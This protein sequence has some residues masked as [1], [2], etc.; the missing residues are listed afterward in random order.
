MGLAACLAAGHA[1]LAVQVVFSEVMYRPTAGKPEF[2]ELWNITHTPL[3]IAQWRFTRG[4]SYTFPEFSDA[5]PQAHILQAQE[6]IV[7]SAAS[8]AETRAAYP[9]IPPDVRVFGPWTGALANEGEEVILEDKNGVVICLLDY[10]NGGNWPKAADGTGHSLV[11]RNEN[12][13]IDSFRNW[14]ASRYA[15]GTPGYSEFGAVTPFP[16][17]SPEVGVGSA[18]VM[19]DYGTTW[20]WHIPTSNPGTAWQGLGFDDSGWS[21]G[22]GLLGFENAG[23]PAPGMQTTVGAPNQ[24]MVTL[25]RKTFTFAGSPVGATVSIDQVIDDGV[26]YYLNGQLLGASGHSP[27]AW[28]ASASRTVGDASEELDAIT[29]PASGLVNGENVLAASVHQVNLSSS[30]MVFGARLKIGTQPGLVINEVKPG[31][32]GDGFVEIYNTTGSPI[33]LQNHYLSDLPGN[34][35]K[36]RIEADLVVPANGYAVIGFAESGLTVGATT[37]VYLTAPDGATA[38][39]AISA[40][41]PVDGRSLGRQ[42]AGGTGW[43]LFALPTPGA[44]NGS[45]TAASFAL[46]LSEAHFSEGGYVDW[47]ELENTDATAGSADGL[48]LA[49]RLDFADRIPLSGQIPGGGFASWDCAFPADSDGTLTLWLIDAGRNVLGWAE[50]RRVPG[51]DSLQALWPPAVPVKPSWEDVPERPWWNATPDHTR[52]AAN[53]PGLQTAIVINEIMPDPPSDH[54]NGEFVELHNRSA[55]PV[56]LTGWKLRGGAD[57]DFAPGATVPAGGFLLVGGDPAFLMATYPGTTAVGPWSGRLANRGELLR[58][59]DE[60]GNLAD[61]V[62]YGVGG[63]W[64]TLAAAQGS[65]LELL[66][67]DMDNSR[68]SAWRASDEASKSEWQTFTITGPWTQLRTMGGPSDYKELHLFLVGDSHIA[69]RNMHLSASTEPGTNLLPGGGATVSANGTGV[70]GWLC[71]GTHAQSYAEDGEFHLVSDGRG[72]N[73]PNRAEIDVTGLT[74]GRTYTLTFEARWISGKNR[75][76]VQTWDHSFGAP[77]L[78]PIP[79]ALGTAGAPNSRFATAPLPQVDSVLHSPAVPKPA[80][81]VR[82]TARVTSRLPLSTV[83]VVHRADDINNAGSWQTAAMVDDGTGGDA[84]ADDGIYTATITDHQTNG[85]V[86]QFYVRATADGGGTSVAPRGG[87]SLPGLW[88]V[89]NRTLDSRLR[90]QRFVVSAYDRDIFSTSGDSPSA[91]Y[92]YKYPRLSNHY[93]NATFIHNESDVYY[94]AEI[95][96]SGSPWTRSSGSDLGRGKWK[97]PRDRFFRGREKNTFD[98]DAEGGSRHHNRITRYWLYVLGHPVNENEFVYHVINNGSLAIREDTEPVDGELVARAYP[99]GGSGQLYRSDDEWWFSDD[100][101]RTPRDADWSYKGTTSTLRYHTEWMARSRESEYDYGPLIEFFRNVT[102]SP[103]YPAATYREVIN[104]LLEPDLVPMMA[105]VRGYIQDWDSLTLDRGKNGY[106]YRRPTDGRFHLLHWDS[107]LAFGSTGGSVVGGHAGWSNYINQPWA[108]R[109]LNYYLNEMLRLTT[110]DRAART[111]SWLAAEEAASSAWSV[112]TGTYQSWFNN[113]EARIRQEI[114]AS[115]GGGGT[116][117]S[118]AAPFAVTTPSGSTTAGTVALSGTAPSS[119]FTI[120]V[121]GQPDAVVT[122]TNQ[123]NWSLSGLVL[124]EGQNEFTLRMIDVAGAQIGDPLTYAYSKSGNA[125][126]VVRLAADP[127]SLNVALGEPLLLDAGQSFDP[128]GGVLEFAWAHLPDGGATVGTPSPAQRTATFHVPGIYTFTVTATDPD[129]QQASLAREILVFNSADFDSFGTT[130]LSP[131]WT[132]QALKVRDNHA[133][134][135]WYSL[136]DVP[137]QCLVHLTDAAALPLSHGSPTFPAL[138][139]PLPAASDIALATVFTYDSK[140]TGAAFTG[141]VVD[142]LEGGTPVRY[143]FGVDGGLNWRV[144]R[145]DGGSFSNVG[146]AL[147]FS[148]LEARLRVRRTGDTLHFER[149]VDGEWSAVTTHVLPAGSTL[150]RG[151]L[152]ASTSAAE[153]VRFA[154]DHALVVDPSNINSQLN[155]LRLTE[156]MYAPK[157]PDTAEWLELMNTGQAPVSLLGVRFVQGTPFDEVVLPDVTVAPG[158]RV[159]LTGNL[160]AFRARYGEDPVVVATWPGGA[161]NNAG[162]EILILDAD[163]NAIHDFAYDDTDPWPT[164]AKSG[165]PSLEVID[166]EGDYGDG[167]NWRASAANGGSPGSDGAVVPPDP[168]ADTDGDGLSDAAEA[169]FGTDLADPFSVPSITIAGAN[170]YTFPSVAGNTYALQASS[171]LLDD[172]WVTIATTIATGPVTTIHDPTDAVHFVRFYRIEAVLP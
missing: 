20:K 123:R 156:I 73:R 21:S 68:P 14:R 3:D 48:F 47:V 52:D 72:D 134:S 129:G 167:R 64:P 104:R 131:R 35:T 89:D 44:S 78:I 41:I 111:L 33:S 46:R 10:G 171:D 114:N 165:G 157:A 112:S 24:T 147:S 19:F 25:F 23:V 109:K 145:S 66:H 138:W 108:R 146:T 93:V 96:K 120:V 36:H 6:R 11:L 172:S 16:G 135:A 13:E 126:P 127:A 30:D 139:R 160:A 163:G 116:G 125:A 67:P 81:P 153:N 142:T 101:N 12:N 92:G 38:L 56:S 9:S 85:R 154:F 51:R 118:Y 4:V 122:W 144:R 105:A 159:V 29:G 40:A 37:V 1:A 2:I 49:S 164:I 7:V 58:L 140:R 149:R 34:L 158:G 152:F 60:Y 148:G 137:G 162:E 124:R 107:D 22:P 82:V 150:V 45:A 141:L 42:P 76:I 90:R 106:F 70:S 74:Q 54:R 102:N 113:R 79:N 133:P 151:G 88:I 83:E 94:N 161:L 100:W 87:A 53:D 80:E 8:E 98:N 169:L 95:R 84:E 63:D 28:N 166:T 50:L 168:D 143:A 170:E 110:G 115:I 61:E 136:E 65:S 57:Y 132:P 91:K 69:L 5:A 31:G 43:F 119:A 59:I 117:N 62:F 155:N 18:A 71:Q 97:V 26:V 27:G 121:D 99:E 17:G 103:S 128:E 39:N 75:L 86:V 32:P 77:L 55:S 130:L 15:G